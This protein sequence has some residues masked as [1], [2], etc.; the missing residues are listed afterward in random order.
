MGK[1]CCH[2]LCFYAGMSVDALISPEFLLLNILD[3]TGKYLKFKET[4]NRIGHE[5]I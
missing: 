3:K 5:E 2:P 1:C 4:I